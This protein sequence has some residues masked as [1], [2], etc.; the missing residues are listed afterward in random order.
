MVEL[1]GLSLKKLLG[2]LWAFSDEIRKL[3]GK[4]S[5][6]CKISADVQSMAEDII[7]TPTYTIK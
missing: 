6:G 5:G 1:S 2:E 3:A 4:P 7:Q